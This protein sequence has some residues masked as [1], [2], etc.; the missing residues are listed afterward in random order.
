MGIIVGKVLRVGGSAP[1]SGPWAAGRLWH[2]GLPAMPLKAT[3]NF[4]NFVVFNS[5]V[6]PLLVLPLL[7][8]RESELS[9]LIN[10]FFFNFLIITNITFCFVF[11][12]HRR[13]DEK[14]LMDGW[15]DGWPGYWC[16]IHNECTLHRK[17]KKTK[18]Y[19]NRG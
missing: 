10:F 1:A 17:L 18:K 2:H 4:R 7:L 9:S 8:P 5:I 16:A 15:M 13:G 6:I 3:E 14:G 12:I 19:V 11:L